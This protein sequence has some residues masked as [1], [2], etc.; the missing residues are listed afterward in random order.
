MRPGLAELLRPEQPVLEQRSLK[1]VCLKMSIP[2]FRLLVLSQGHIPSATSLAVGKSRDM[3]IA[4]LLPSALTALHA[5]LTD[6]P[7]P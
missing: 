6:P 3:P 7:A 1:L 2:L 5:G 4:G